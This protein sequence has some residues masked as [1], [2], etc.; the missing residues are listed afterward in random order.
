MCEKI[1]INEDLKNKIAIFGALTREEIEKI[2]EYVQRERY[3][4][5][6]KIFSQNSSPEGIYILEEGETSV[7]CHHNNKDYTLKNYYP[8]DS[9]G[10][11]AFLGITSNLGDCVALNEV[12][13]LKISKFS[14]HKLSKVDHL[15][16]IKFLLNITREICRYNCFL[17]NKFI[18]KSEVDIV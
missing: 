13:L 9:F 10:Q 14:F 3:S 6:E 2:L 4:K 11:I 1:F 7:I 18:E 12:T 16:F 5:G 15:L 17:T 8:G